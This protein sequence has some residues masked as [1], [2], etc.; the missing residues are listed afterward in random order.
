MYN[1]FYEMTLEQEAEHMEIENQF[2]TIDVS[3]NPMD[4]FFYHVYTDTLPLE[5]AYRCEP[6]RK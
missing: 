6:L 2:R 5:T 1:R 3:N 4:P